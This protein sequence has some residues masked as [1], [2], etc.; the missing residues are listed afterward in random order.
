MQIQ[1]EALFLPEDVVIET[2]DG[3]GPSDEEFAKLW[4]ET[5][6][7]EPQIVSLGGALVVPD[8][9]LPNIV[10][11]P[12]EMSDLHIKKEFSCGVFVLLFSVGS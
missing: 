4:S 12:V 5:D 6:P 10:H 11:L 7:E 2:G 3:P 9:S 1:E 8:G